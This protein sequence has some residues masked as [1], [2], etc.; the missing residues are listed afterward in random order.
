[1]KRPMKPAVLIAAALLA[2]LPLGPGAAGKGSAA[3]PNTVVVFVTPLKAGPGEEAEL[4]VGIDRNAAVIGAFGL[5]VSFP[6]SMFTYLDV[7]K[8]GLT[9]DWTTVNA[10]QIGPGR[11]RV[12]GFAGAGPKIASG[13][14]GTLAVLRFKV[15][16]GSCPN[17]T[18]A[19]SC[20]SAFVDGLA[21]MA[22]TGSCALFTLIQ[23]TDR[24]PGLSNR[25]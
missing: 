19:R 18:T 14:S 16:C 25:E 12:G 8:G 13:R 21:G 15:S 5:D 11:V 3:D 10:N 6:T 9:E 20:L 22:G 4:V 24:N 2:L 17:G 1:M 7:Q 23:K